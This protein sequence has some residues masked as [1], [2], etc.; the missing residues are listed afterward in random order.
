[1]R[2]EEGSSTFPKTKLDAYDKHIAEKTEMRNLREVHRDSTEKLII[3]FDL[4][5][6]INLPHAYISS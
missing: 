1:M 6:V 4:E 3:C 2:R 5:N